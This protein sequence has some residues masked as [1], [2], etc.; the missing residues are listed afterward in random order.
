M[1]KKAAAA[2]AAAE[3]AKAAQLKPPD[4]MQLGFQNTVFDMGMLLVSKVDTPCSF[5]LDQSF[6]LILILSGFFL[7]II[8]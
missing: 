6:L 4:G 2:A 7:Q 1:T 3:A 5:H 8:R